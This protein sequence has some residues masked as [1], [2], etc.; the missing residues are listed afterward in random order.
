MSTQPNTESIVYPLPES[1]QELA[2]L[3]QQIT[4]YDSPRA[5]IIDY[6]QK[7]I[8]VHPSTDE[9]K[10][11]FTKES[12]MYLLSAEPIN[13]VDDISSLDA[14]LAKVEPEEEFITLCLHP[15]QKPNLQDVHPTL[16]TP[17]VSEN[18]VL[19]VVR[20]S[21]SQKWKVLGASLPDHLHIDLG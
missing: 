15:N 7:T 8:L 19:M 5:V 3:V 14:L 21:D 4:E 6:L 1:S 13:M 9:D 20:V 18:S 2:G 10:A 11:E 16:W 17:L 12:L